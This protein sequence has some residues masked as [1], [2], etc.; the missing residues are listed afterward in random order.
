MRLTALASLEKACA[1]ARILRVFQ[2]EDLDRNPTTDGV[3]DG[4]KDRSMPPS[5]SLRTT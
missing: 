1:D 4:L 3:L 5:P 2:V